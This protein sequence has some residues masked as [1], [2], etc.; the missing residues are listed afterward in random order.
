[1]YR[2]Q[3]QQFHFSS[4]DE[5]ILRETEI[6]YSTGPGT[7]LHDF[8]ALLDYVLKRKLRLT[9]TLQLPLRALPEINERLAMPVAHG[10]Q[11]PLQK[12]LPP[13][14][15]LYLVLRASGLTYVDRSGSKPYLLIDDDVY[16]V[17]QA[18][19]AT[20]RYG[21]LLESWL[22]RGRADIIGERVDPYGG[23]PD[24]FYTSASFLADIPDEGLQVAGDS[25]IETSFSY[26]PEW[27]NLGL[28]SLFGCV[29][30]EQGEAG[31]G[32]RWQIARIFRTPFGGALFSLLVDRLF[33]DFDKVDGLMDDGKT[34]VGVLQRIVRPFLRDWSE[35]L[36]I[37]EQGSRDGVHV[38][39]VSLGSLWRRIAIPADAYFDDLASAI[40]SSVEFSHDHLYYF[41]YRDRFG[42][43]K[44][45]YHPYMEEGASSS[46]ARI[47]DVPIQVGQVLTFL[48]DFG[49]QWEFQVTLERV[50]PDID[51]DSATVIATHGESPEQYPTWSQDTWE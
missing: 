25:D 38:F 48:Y 24:N 10:L 6:G 7:I 37:P 12:S 14:H 43:E 31:P 23:I 32:D 2:Y 11:R 15:G 46:E 30:I 17:W 42:S 36:V 39:L 8:E 5:K 44:Y 19:N 35:N 40:I 29:R 49:D 47:G 13:V 33:G 34:L 1:M 3:K 26:R 27:H 51:V 4:K 9:N 20:E 50:E 21:S 22:L 28:L 45:L 41:A 18:L 16:R